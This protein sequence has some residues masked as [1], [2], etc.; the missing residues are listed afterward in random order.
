MVQTDS[1][2]KLIFIV[3]PTACGKSDFAIE[4]AKE[5]DGEIISADSMQIYKKLNIGTAKISTEEM[6]GIKHYML[7]IIEPENEFSVADYRQLA[8]DCITQITSRD[9]ISIVAGGTGLYV[10][11]LI[12]PMTYGE[13]SK[14]SEL[15]EQLN[16]ELELKGAAYI[17]SKL[18]ELD[19]E[20]ADK[21]H[22]NNTRRVIRAIEISLAGVNKSSLDDKRTPIRDYLMIG[23]NIDREILYSR[24]NQRVDK[25]FEGGLLSEVECFKNE[26]YLQSMQAIGYKEFKEY[27]TGNIALEGVK[28]LIKKNTRNYAK[29]Q[30]TWFKRYQ[31]IVWFNPLTQA[32]EAI[33]YVKRNI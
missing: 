13:T 21:L 11:S 26:L 33:D 16:R 10:D 5:I 14:N 31:D 7:D 3:G 1:I 6:Q 30:L 23:L 22:P 4:L 2:K 9:K 24:I 32:K 8:E 17:H 15:R 28:E 12:Y 27:F 29:R 25:M 18:K 20:T 19:P